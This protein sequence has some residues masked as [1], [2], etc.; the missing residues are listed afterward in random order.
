MYKNNFFFYKTRPKQDYIFMI[1]K[2]IQ[3]LN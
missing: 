2:H 3:S 1:L